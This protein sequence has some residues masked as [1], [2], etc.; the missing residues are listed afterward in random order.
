MGVFAAVAAGITWAV[1]TGMVVSYPATISAT[2]NLASETIS[3]VTVQAYLPTGG[4]PASTTVAGAGPQ[5]VNVAV[6]GGNWADTDSNPA[7]DDDPGVSYTTYAYAYL[8]NPLSSQTSLRA[9]KNAGILVN[10]TTATPSVT[11]PVSFVYPQT[12]RAN[13]TISVIGNAT[14][15]NYYLYASASNATV[16]ESYFGTTNGSTNLQTSV[17]TWVPMAPASSVQIYGTVYLR[18]SD[19]TTT[20]RSLATQ[21]KDLSAS[22]ASV[23]WTIDLTNTGHLQGAIAITSPDAA[24][25]G[26]V[27]EYYG[28]SSATSGISG[29]ISATTSLAQYAVDLT[30]GD[31]DIQLLTSYSNPSSQSET[32]R[33]RI[34]VAAGATVT[35]DFTNS[36][37]KLRFPLSVGGF[38]TNAD[39]TNSSSSLRGPTYNNWAYSWQLVGGNY[40]QVV[41]FGSWQKYYTSISLYN[42]SD[43]LAPL[44]DYITRYTFD[45]AS[46]PPINVSSAGIT[47]APTEQVSLVKTNIYF[48]VV[49]APGVPAIQ[50]SNPQ[51]NAYKVESNPGGSARAQTSVWAYGSSTPQALSKFVMVAEPGTYTISSAI[52]TVNGR[53]TTFRSGTLIFGQPMSTDPGTPSIVLVNET[54]GPHLNLSLNFGNVTKSGVTTVVENPL[55]PPPP[56]GYKMACQ[57]LSCDPIY[58]DITSNATW[59][60]TTKVC[61][62][63][64]S[65]LPNGVAQDMLKLNHFNSGTAAWEELPAPAD[66]TPQFFDCSADLTQCGCASE[67]VCGIDYTT[68]P[69]LPVN[70]YRVCGDTASFSPFALF[71]KKLRF[72]N[73]VNGVTYTGPTGPPNLQQWVVPGDGTYRITATGARGAAATASPTLNGG[74]GA[75]VTGDFT[76]QEGDVVQLLVGQKGTAVTNSAGGGG[77]TFVTRNGVALLIA[78]GGGGVR[79]GALVDGR[80]GSLGSAGVAGSTSNSYASGFIAGGTNGSGGARILSY[81][82][83]GGGWS[84]DGAADGSYGEGGFSF[85]GA[86]QGKGGAGK[87][88]TGGL[89]HGGY[90]GGGAGNGCYGGGG[91]GGYSGGGGGRVGG[92]GG[93]LNNGAN[94]TG[95]EGSTACTPNGQGL[96]TIDYL[97]P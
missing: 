85:L 6:D 45:D 14:I 18:N 44:N 75:Q 23:N 82:S 76:L 73:V 60:H 91:G 47:S 74:C 89:A 51:I 78:G 71:Q 72:D 40:D 42:N 57:D 25:S 96:V 90:G 54:Q 92:G 29:S 39:L 53:Q 83:G 8:V 93:S 69:D 17:A 30:P 13:A 55:G 62:R 61:V 37:G 9:S 4:S 56:E 94:P 67:A 38:F 19:G 33:T 95:I 68:N 7:T 88:C 20:Q 64:T 28:A 77:G 34:T 43:P 21:I 52:A 81:G 46:L 58:Y 50:I 27:V 16:G 41:P 65:T 48:D 87:T 80:N 31:Y 3:S 49:E 32:L 66:G 1:A 10:N 97:K 15:S 86:S 63:R 12:H 70:A 2:V 35:K 26:Y 36:Y 79:S 11:V 84:G 24:P 22:S 59:D 5:V